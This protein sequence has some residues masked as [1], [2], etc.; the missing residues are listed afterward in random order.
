M[1]FVD[2]G[3]DS[4]W[5]SYTDENGQQRI[6]YTQG[7]EYRGENSTVAH[8]VSVL[9]A[10]NSTQNGELVLTALS[11]SQN[12]F[13]ITRG[14][15]EDGTAGFKPKSAGGGDLLMGNS[16]DLLSTAHEMFHAYQHEHGQ[17]GRS[18]FNELEA[19]LFSDGVNFEYH[20][21]YTGAPAGSYSQGQ[22]LNEEAI[23]FSNSV[24]ELRY[25]PFFIEQSF[26]T[27]VN[28]FKRNS[29]ANINGQY[30]HY[31]LRKNNQTNNLIKCFYPLFK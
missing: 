29:G 12:N 9:N 26:N 21:N 6:L 4:I 20:S 28:L 15:S 17:G 13:N 8:F 18:I 5:I 24:S 27:A 22:S 1:N 23:K 19:Y 31:P 10:M 3:G 16:D 14:K 25:S 11:S 2:V 7:M 30:D